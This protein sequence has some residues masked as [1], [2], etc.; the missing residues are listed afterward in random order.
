MQAALLHPGKQLRVH[1]SPAL[2]GGRSPCAQYTC[3]S[4]LHA[5]SKPILMGK[6]TSHAGCLQCRIGTQ[7]HQLV[8]AACFGR[9]S[10]LL[11]VHT[12]FLATLH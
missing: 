12:L 4:F 6:N 5:A 7:W 9:R 8:F 1:P 10:S 3:E 2:T 11:C